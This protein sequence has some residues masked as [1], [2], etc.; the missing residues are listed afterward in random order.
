MAVPTLDKLHRPVLEIANASAQPLTRKEFLDRLTTKFSL[1]EADLQEMVPSGVQSRMENRTNWAMTDLKKAG[2][3]NNPHRNQWKITQEG[4]DYLV[5]QEDIIKF[6]DLQKLWPEYQES[7]TEPAVET[8]DAVDITPDEQIAKSHAQHQN[9][10]S[11]SI[12]DSAKSVTDSGFERLVVELLS[13]MGYGDGLVT[14]R[15]GDHGIDGILD[16]DP[17]GLEK[18]YVQAKRYTSNQVSERDIRDFA[19]SLDLQGATKGVFITTSSFGPSARR[20]AD[21]ITKRTNKLIRVIDGKELAALMIQHTVG[22]I[23]EVTYEVKKL[24]ANYFDD[25]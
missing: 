25:I 21:E 20:A 18:V 19:G 3:I 7:S 1:T 5:K 11:D 23:T 4:R 15:S 9:M 24:D 12:L 8:L 2:L 10:L 14:G 6:V 13:R 22:V 17:L 16:Q